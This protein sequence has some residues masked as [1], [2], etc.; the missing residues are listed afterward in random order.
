MAEPKWYQ[1]ITPYQWRV[2]YCTCLGWALDI[3]D[4]YLYAIILFPAMSDLLGTSEPAVIGLIAVGS[5][6]AVTHHPDEW[7]D[8]DVFVVTTAGAS[9]GLL[10]DPSWLPDAGRIV[11][12][13]TET[14][15]GRAAVYDDGHLIE[16][17]VA[18][19]ARVIVTRNLR[20]VAHGE[21]KFPSL[22]VLTPEQC[23]EVF[24]CPP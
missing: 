13:H 6:A 16:L 18:A 9:A 1:D 19:Q 21:L 8:H 10:E 2:L 15:D 5:T 20:D 23:L 24:P 3:M 22:R 4:G 12:W 17:A 11:M 14:P 7:S